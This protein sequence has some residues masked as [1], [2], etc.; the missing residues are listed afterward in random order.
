MYELVPLDAIE[1]EIVD[2]EPVKC[3]A[4]DPFEHGFENEPV[5]LDADG[6]DEWERCG[7]PA[8]DPVHTPGDLDV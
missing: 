6:Y 7:R 2:D 5:R 3:T 4:T 8:N 1:G